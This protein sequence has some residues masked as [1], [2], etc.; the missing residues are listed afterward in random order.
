MTFKGYMESSED[1]I[2]RVEQLEASLVWEIDSTS[3][4]YR[5]VS[6]ESK[7]IVAHIKWNYDKVQASGEDVNAYAVNRGTG[8][9]SV[10]SNHY[11][12]ERESNSFTDLEGAKKCAKFGAIREILSED[13]R[14]AMFQ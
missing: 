9:W 10:F 4:G 13:L 12:G 14:K 7:R 5:L 1:I 6:K 2:S 3:A 11:N 8:T